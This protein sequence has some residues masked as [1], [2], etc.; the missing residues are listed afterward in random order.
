MRRGLDVDDALA[1]LCKSGAAPSWVTPVRAVSVAASSGSLL[2]LPPAA[3]LKTAHQRF[4]RYFLGTRPASASASKQRLLKL[5]LF[6]A[7]SMQL[8]SAAEPTL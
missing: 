8:R 2:M 1:Y 4:L 7:N 3:I 5:P 6:P